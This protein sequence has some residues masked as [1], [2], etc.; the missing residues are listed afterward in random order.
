MRYA[1][2]FRRS[3]ITTLIGGMTSTTC[4]CFAQPVN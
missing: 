4:P 1:L 3:V 2:P